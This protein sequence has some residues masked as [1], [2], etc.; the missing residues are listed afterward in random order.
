LATWGIRGAVLLW[1]LQLLTPPS[2]RA[3]MGEPQIVQ[4]NT[5]HVCIHTRLIDEVH[6]W[7]ILRSLELVRE[8]GATTIVEFFP[9][10]YFEPS[11]DRYDWSRAELILKFAQNQGLHVIARLGL[12][13]AWA[14]E[15]ESSYSTL[16]TLPEDAYDDFAQFAADFAARYEGIV[17]EII[18]WNEP[19]LAFEWG[20][21]QVN[22]A[23]Y[24]Q[25]V[26]T[27]YQA[28]K[29]AA[30]SV[31]V[32]AGAL[33]PT[34]EPVGSPNGLSDLLYLQAMYDAGIQAYFDGLAIHTYGFNLPALDKPAAQKLNFRRAELLH[35]IMVEN[36]DATKPV[37][38]TESGWNDHPRWAYGVRPSQRVEYTIEAFKLAETSWQW[39]KTVCNWV[40]RYP[41]PTNSY[42]DNFTIAGTN[43]ELKPLYYAIQ[44]Y[45]QGRTT[46]EDLWLPAPSPSLP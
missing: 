20:F 12:V 44:D 23:A 39:A 3:I 13:P 19:N 26:K 29:A 38:I 6:E 8:M 46:S 24:V 37:F 17:T 18:V 4:T 28:I 7:K 31:L 25:L 32:L 5:P 22:P 33:A 10:A 9:W 14:R 2:A 16:N 45:T 15:S 11:E 41:A 35:N 30:P 21:R 34:L 27:T 42:P 1:V 43:F 40:F 36:G